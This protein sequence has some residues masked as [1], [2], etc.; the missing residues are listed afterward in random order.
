MI[1]SRHFMNV[2]HAHLDRIR[3]RRATVSYNL[4]PID[5][6]FLRRVKIRYKPNRAD[7]C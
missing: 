6:Q 3:R 5:N 1:C 4:T 2:L 7:F